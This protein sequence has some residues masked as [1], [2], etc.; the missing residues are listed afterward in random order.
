MAPVEPEAGRAE[1]TG[2]L[3]GIQPPG[4]KLGITVHTRLRQATEQAVFFLFFF[5][6]VVYDEVY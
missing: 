6:D 3:M 5:Y 2:R 1:Q 4:S